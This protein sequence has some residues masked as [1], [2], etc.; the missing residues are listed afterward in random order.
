MIPSSVVSFFIDGVSTLLSHAQYLSLF[1]GAS[2]LLVLRF[3][4]GRGSLDRNGTMLPIFLLALV[5]HALLASSGDFF[6]YEAY[7]VGLGVFAIGMNI[8]HLHWDLPAPGGRGATLRALAGWAVLMF[9]MQPLAQRATRALTAVP[10][11]L[12]NRFDEHLQLARFVSSHYPRSKIAMHDIGA[13]AFYTDAEILD[14]FGLASQE[15]L[16]RRREPEWVYGGRRLRV[17]TR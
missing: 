16:A 14:I 8:A 15:P 2:F 13:V 4:T 6:R 5:Q 3:L 12:A 11:A 1:L 9:L 17:G 10:E 7:V